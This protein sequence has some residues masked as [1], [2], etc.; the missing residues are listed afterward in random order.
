MAGF[1]TLRLP[2]F[3]CDTK[4][5]SDACPSTCVYANYKLYAYINTSELKAR[6]ARD[7]VIDAINAEGVPCFHGSCSEVYLE[8][9]F[10]GPS[11]RPKSRLPIARELGETALMFLVHPTL[12]DADIQKTCSAI[13]HVMCIASK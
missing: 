10:D 7:K 6:W 1:K 9:T 12:T 8:K 3:K 13:K 4:T 5:C 2:A 11:W